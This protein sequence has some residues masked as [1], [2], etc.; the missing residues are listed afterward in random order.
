MTKYNQGKIYKITSPLTANIYIGSTTVALCK[1]MAEH[2]ERTKITFCASRELIKLG[3]AVITLIKYAPC[4]TKEELLRAERECIE[5]HIK[6]GITLVNK[7]SP[8]NDIDEHKNNRNEK[9]ACECGGKYTKSHVLHHLQSPKH[10]RFIQLKSD[11]ATMPVID[12]TPLNMRDNIPTV[13]INDKDPVN[14]N[15]IDFI[16]EIP[17]QKKVICECGGK[18]TKSNIKFHLQTK[19]H[20][21]Y[22]TDTHTSM[23]THTT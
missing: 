9:F 6:R 8:I 7:T 5:E 1:R 10:R 16:I 4:E 11:N 23:T 22:L 21:D 12:I 18:Y 17:S 3:D 14:L 15:D 13:V 19:T 20:T 2:R